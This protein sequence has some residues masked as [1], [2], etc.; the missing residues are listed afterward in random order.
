MTPH[1]V[2][3]G[4]GFRVPALT[5]GRKNNTMRRF[6]FALTLAAPL[7]CVDEIDDTEDMSELEDSADDEFR[8]SQYTDLTITP[9]PGTQPGIGPWWCPW[10]DDYTCGSCNSWT[11]DNGHTCIVCSGSDCNCSVG[12]P[13]WTH[14]VSGIVFTNF[15]YP[16]VPCTHNGRPC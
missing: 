6:L 12:A 13:P 7:G 2:A 16:S 3:W 4:R 11:A 9:P 10:C 1:P 8:E 14:P 5:V 15:F